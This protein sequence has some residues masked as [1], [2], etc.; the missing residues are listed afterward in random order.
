MKKIYLY[1]SPEGGVPLLEFMAALDEKAQKKVEY[2][3]KSMAISRGRLSEPQV[4]HFSIER[5]RQLYEIREKARVLIRVIFALDGDGNVILLHP[6]IKRHKRNTN[7]ALET[8]LAM[9]EEIKQNPD[10]LL[11][12]P[13]DGRIPGNQQGGSTL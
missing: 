8:S 2:A 10:I 1:K 6:F 9:L 5:Y 3:F 13:F 7:Q 11:E 4:K 12:Y